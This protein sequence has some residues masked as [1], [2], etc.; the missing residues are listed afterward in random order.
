MVVYLFYLIGFKIKIN[1][2]MKYFWWFFVWLINIMI[3]VIKKFI[4]FNDCNFK[5]YLNNY[6]ILIEEYSLNWDLKFLNI[7]VNMIIFLNII[8]FFY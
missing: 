5:K 1:V 7:Y 4:L 3:I 8:I 6:Y 2:S